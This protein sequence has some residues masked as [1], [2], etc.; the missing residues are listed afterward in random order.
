MVLFSLEKVL[1]H[2][3]VTLDLT[4]EL[5]EVIPLKGKRFE[6]EE[7]GIDGEGIDIREGRKD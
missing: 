1:H 4:I 7:R 2:V 3:D 6:T 5:S